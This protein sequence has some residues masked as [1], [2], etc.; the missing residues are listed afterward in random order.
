[1]KTTTPAI[2]VIDDDDSSRDAVTE[3]LEALG[4]P[5]PYGL[6]HGI[7]AL[8]RMQE[9]LP[10]LVFV[11]VEEP[12][13]RTLTTVEFA[14]MVNPDTRVVCYSNTRSVAIAQKMLRAGANELLPS[15]IRVEDLRGAL[16]RA[17]LG[18][19]RGP[20]G[21]PRTR[22]TITVVCG[23]KGGIGKTTI[24]TNIASALAAGGDHAVLIIDLD[25]RFGDVGVMMDLQPEV[26]AAVA[27]LHVDG[28]DRDTFREI[29][30]RHESGAFVLAAPTSRHDWQNAEPEQVAK[31]IQFAAEMFDHVILDTPGTMNRMVATGI[32]MADKIVAVTS[33]HPTSVKNTALLL[34]YLRTREVAR[35]RVVITVNHNVPDDGT[36]I[37]RLERH[38]R[39][40]VDHVIPFDDAVARACQKGR[41]VVLD[42]PRSRAAQAFV[43]LASLLGEAPAAAPVKQVPAKPAAHPSPAAIASGTL[44][45][46]MKGLLM[47]S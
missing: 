26:T 41:P 3:A 5:A 43:A 31:L 16:N 40:R 47:G 7:G 15:P 36:E 38:L 46:R 44:Q 2:L 42:R 35:E 9:F 37:A 10:P 45:K 12:Y 14:R 11:A 28:L 19:R 20:G 24:S 21:G 18:D 29:L 8:Y 23:Q 17:G 30:G 4:A 32:E 25:M 39:A 13:A 34:N 27:A 6:R 22:G 33:P 1:M